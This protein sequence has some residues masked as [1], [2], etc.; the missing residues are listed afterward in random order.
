MVA[1][2]QTGTNDRKKNTSLRY[3]VFDSLCS[4][5]IERSMLSRYLRRRPVIKAKPYQDSSRVALV[6]QRHQKTSPF[7]SHSIHS[8]SE[9]DALKVFPGELDH[10]I[11]PLLIHPWV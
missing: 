11:L 1:V 6:K 9:H 5:R 4:A 10:R 8:S 3:D 7:T 2:N